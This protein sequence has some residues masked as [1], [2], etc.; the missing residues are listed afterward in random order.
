MGGLSLTMMETVRRCGLP[1]VAFVHDE[2][3]AY[4]RWADA[5]LCSFAGRWARVA[6]LARRASGI[7]T[8]VDFAGAA[9][10]IFVSDAIRRHALGLGLGLRSTG[11]AH[12]GIDPSFLDPAPVQEWRWR[13]LYVGRVDPRK[14]VHTAVLAMQHF[15]ANARLDIFGGWDAAEETRLRELA[16]RSE[17]DQRVHFLGHRGRDELKP[18]YAASDVVVFPVDWEEP[19]GLVPLEAMARGRP[20]VATGRGG[21]G[22]YLRDGENCLLFEAGDA[23]GLAQVLHRLA[24]NPTLRD[25][26][27]D[28]GL[29]TAS[30][31]TEPMF[32]DAV[33]RALER[34][35]S[36]HRPR[37]V[38]AL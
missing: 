7:P 10:Y 29:A 11:V 22:E 3:L 24:E 28:G 38:P 16:S 1:A 37:G 9:T 17:V 35:V 26:L 23:E 2:W 14:G 19:W 20:V 25:R 18:A 36:D 31:H 8:T 4:G 13:L 27:R 6:P 15:P 33:E 21:S 34:A 30:Q 12:S 5:W 32:N